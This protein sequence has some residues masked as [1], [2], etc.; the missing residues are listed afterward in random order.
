M[1][2]DWKNY[3]HFA[4]FVLSTENAD[5][6]HE[7]KIRNAISRLF[8]HAFHC[9]EN[10]AIKSLRYESTDTNTHGSL[11]SHLV[12]CRH[13]PKADLYDELRRIRG[14]CDYNH[15]TPTDLEALLL[16]ARAVHARLVE[17]LQAYSR[18]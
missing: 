2:Y 14:F 1:C 13:R 9:L 11:R 17:P 12:K 4:D 3:N 7:T 10:W 18:L 5:L 16:K 15:E 6:D 8:Y